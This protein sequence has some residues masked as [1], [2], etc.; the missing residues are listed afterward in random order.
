MKSLQRVRVGLSV[1]VP[2]QLMAAIMLCLFLK[3]QGYTQTIPTVTN[4]GPIGV[5]SNSPLRDGETL[6]LYA[7]GGISYDW[8]GPNGFTSDQAVVEFG[9]ISPADT[10]V[11]SVTVTSQ[12]VDS[13]AVYSTNVFLKA[14]VPI[15]LEATNYEVCIN[16]PLELYSN[17][18]SPTYTYV[19]ST[20]I[21]NV[22]IPQVPN[23]GHVQIPNGTTQ[24]TYNVYLAIF[25]GTT[26][27]CSDYITIKIY[28]CCLDPG[29]VN[30]VTILY[31]ETT[32]NQS[33]VFTDHTV[34][35]GTLI[36]PANFSIPGNVN[37][38]T[39]LPNS[40]IF[41]HDATLSAAYIDFHGC[42]DL[43]RSIV[44]NESSSVDFLECTIR[45]GKWALSNVSSN[46]LTSPT[47]SL[48]S[49]I[50]RDNYNSIDVFDC[51][52]I[53]DLNDNKFYTKD[54]LLPTLTDPVNV[55]IWIDNCNG[56]TLSGNA[57]NEFY[58]MNTG[59]VTWNSDLTIASDAA[60]FYNFVGTPTLKTAI[61]AVNHNSSLPL[62]LTKHGNTNQ[63]DFNVCDYGIA[64]MNCACNIRDNSFESV[65][66]G[67]ASVGA[68]H[69]SLR[70]INNTFGCSAGGIYANSYGPLYSLDIN[71]NTFYLAPSSTSQNTF[72]INVSTYGYYPDS[73]ANID[74]NSVSVYAG[75]NGIMLNSCYGV[76]VT[77]NSVQLNDCN[78]NLSGIKITS[79]GDNFVLCNNV[80]G[81]DPGCQNSTTTPNGIS[82][83]GS[84]DGHYGFNETDQTYI[85][86]LFDAYSGNTDIYEHNCYDHSYG[87]YY[88]SSGLTGD[89]YHNGNSWLASSYPSYA[90]FEDNSTA[91][92]GV[93]YIGTNGSFPNP[94]Y[95][96]NVVYNTGLIEATGVSPCSGGGG[97]GASASA[98]IVLN[99][100]SSLDSSV[101]TD[102]L[103]FS[104]Y[105]SASVWNAQRV[106]V[107][108]L[109]SDSVQIY[110]NS[111]MF[112]YVDSIKYESPGLFQILENDISSSMQLSSNEVSLIDSLLDSLE[113]ISQQ[114]S[115]LDA[116][117]VN[118]SSA[119]PSISLLNSRSQLI[120]QS[121]DIEDNIRIVINSHDSIFSTLIPQFLTLNSKLPDTGVYENNQKV[122]NNVY[123][124]SVVP[125]L[126]LTSNQ[127]NAILDIAEQCP[128]SGGKAVYLA[129]TLVALFKDTTYYDTG[130]CI[131]IGNSKSQAVN[132][133]EPSSFTFYPNPAS[134]SITV[135][136]EGNQEGKASIS[137]FD[138]SG[139][140]VSSL[141]IQ[142]N[143]K[144]TDIEVAALHNGM[145]TISIQY[146]G[147]QYNLGNLIIN[148]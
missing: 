99:E 130:K 54:N 38:V 2:Y 16:S 100:F 104:S 8:S 69:R 47:I 144:Y 17:T 75:E 58:E 118:N 57:V 103:S 82:V 28:N 29:N 122:L 135:E 37:E 35:L 107:S 53:L 126:E 14:A 85:G 138:L 1:K 60:I 44:L 4:Q 56:S 26:L 76:S 73:Y 136:N 95:P 125:G 89:Q 20:T 40:S 3:I 25:D 66:Y 42:E 129:R 87:L 64:L 127:K 124:H 50:L 18:Y 48:N 90:L 21:P 131:P 115:L 77:E 109:I 134:K 59:I 133:E 5:V 116:A 45:D 102:Q 23:P 114:I 140:L 86:V 34:I 15:C 11:Y 147:K 121:L 91:W 27:I 92:G 62:T 70:M 12:Y 139:K 7:Q 94:Y 80:I 120:A 143:H 137:I 105:S 52:P 65:S 72:G 128:I 96:S 39:L 46:Q 112:S 33:L 81:Q 36:V 24:G 51:S 22:T 148:N 98:A 123:L 41:V 142:L 113:T 30:P 84:P 101:V 43:W 132:I 119:L 74:N 141:N 13:L 83:I 79:G 111:L 63:T 9:G 88:T 32:I 67:I 93:Y 61:L 10:G 108:K 49:C 110:S 117:I 6:Y 106:L 68:I 146:E 55:G 19:W 71:E 97:G 78:T 145:Y 31:N